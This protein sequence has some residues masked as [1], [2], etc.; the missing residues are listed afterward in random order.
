MAKTG[1]DEGSPV[2]ALCAKPGDTDDTDHQGMDHIGALV[3]TEARSQHWFREPVTRQR[4]HDHIEGVGWVATV[5]RRIG[6][7]RGHLRHL[8]ERTG[9]TV[10]QDQRE[11]IGPDARA[12]C[13]VDPPAGYLGAPTW[14]PVVQH[15][16]LR[17]PV[18]ALH[19]EVGELPEV[20]D[21]RAVRP[22]GADH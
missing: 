11:G 5:P 13:E 7:E 19:P 22:A 8:G 12:A 10:Q 4:G 21:I 9:P 6:E 15:A 1:R 14:E 2:T 17:P 16:F 20:V 18:E 3:G